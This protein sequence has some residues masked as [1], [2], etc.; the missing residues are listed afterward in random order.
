[1]SRL[2]ELENILTA[3]SL[4]DC[5]DFNLVHTLSPL[6]QRFV[7]NAYDDRT[8]L[9]EL[10]ETHESR[11]E[12]LKDELDNETSRADNLSDRCDELEADLEDAQDKISELEAK[13]DRMESAL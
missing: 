5:H 7:D 3:N 8:A 13:I 11:I 12:E 1:M 10:E 6:V 4:A 9:E 2:T